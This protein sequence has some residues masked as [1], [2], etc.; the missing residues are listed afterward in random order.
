MSVAYSKTSPQ[1]SV[2]TYL[3]W[4]HI[5]VCQI[6]SGRTVNTVGTETWITYCTE[7]CT[8]LYCTV[9]YCTVLS[10]Y[11]AKRRE[12]QENT[13]MRSKEFLKAQPKGTPETECWYFPVLPK[14]QKL[15]NL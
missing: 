15:S 2:P 9:L 5:V 11:L 14:A 8:V 7:Y 13:T 6:F 4:P 1:F 3:R 10:L 12:V